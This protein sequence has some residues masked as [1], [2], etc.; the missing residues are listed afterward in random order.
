MLVFYRVRA[1]RVQIVRVIN[2]SRDLPPLLN[3]VGEE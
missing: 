1:D 2:S 3:D